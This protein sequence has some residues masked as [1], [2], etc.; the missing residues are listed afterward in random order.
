MGDQSATS[1]ASVF[2]NAHNAVHFIFE[3]LPA[4]LQRPGLGIICG[5]G[6]GGL[7]D[8]ILSQPRHE[9]PYSTIP[10][11][12]LSSV[13]G[14]AGKLVFGITRQDASPIVFMVGRVHYYEG[15]SFQSI[16]FPVR[17]MKVLGVDT[18]L[19][20]NA[21]GGLNPQYS[22]GDVVLLSDHL[23]LAGLAG[24]HP[25]RGPNLEDFGTRFPALSD[26][27]DLHLRR[28]AHEIW[29][30]IDRYSDSRR[31]HEGTYAFVGGPRYP[32]IPTVPL[33]T[34]N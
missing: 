27:Y 8:T 18:L 23:N 1:S 25:L 15:H 28:R 12:P 21:A 14:H 26:A 31:L 9:I 34:Q 19:I 10:H 30:K 6:L 22:V 33:Y 11:F 3:Q 29:K 4:D 24:N 2:Q 5:S 20:T 17:V 16:A 13:H 7:A 32:P